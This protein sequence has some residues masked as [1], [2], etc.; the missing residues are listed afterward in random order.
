MMGKY[1]CKWLFPSVMIGYTFIICFG[2]H[3]FPEV[4]EKLVRIA[5]VI[6]LAQVVLLTVSTASI[7]YKSLSVPI[8]QPN[9]LKPDVVHAWV[10]PNYNEE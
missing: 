9:E 6:V 2:P 10:L 7:L 3:L 1:G 5:V 4:H 8:R